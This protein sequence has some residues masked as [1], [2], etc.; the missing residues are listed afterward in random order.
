[1]AGPGS[2]LYNSDMKGSPLTIGCIAVLLPLV[3]LR[4]ATPT[5][6][7]GEYADKKFMNGQAVL[8]LSL[9]QNGNTVTIFFTGVRSDGQGAAPEI[10]ATG[11]VIGK[12]TVEFK[13]QDDL[14]NSGTGTIARAGD[15]VT[16]SIKP[17]RVA[18]PRCLQFYKQN[19]R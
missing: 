11:N 3:L 13:F 4:A 17:T 5:N 15:D 1:M 6:F 16:V 19:M 8:Q 18:D 2:T 12:G 10:N 9:D 7:A 14:K